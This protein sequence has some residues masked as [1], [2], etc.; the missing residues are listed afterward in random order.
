MESST[1]PALADFA[2]LVSIVSFIIGVVVLVAFF[3]MASNVG[4]ISRVIKEMHTEQIDMAASLRKLSGIE[5]Q[6][7]KARKFDAAIEAAKK[8]EHSNL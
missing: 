5:T 3:T 1:A 7:D 2:A 8:R 6:D 4:T